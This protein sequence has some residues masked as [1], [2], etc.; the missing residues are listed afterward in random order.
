MTRDELIGINAG[1]VKDVTENLL[2][3]SPNVILVIA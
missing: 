1:I 3:Y 2:S